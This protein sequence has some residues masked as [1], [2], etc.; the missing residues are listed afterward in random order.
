MPSFQGKVGPPITSGNS[1]LL[2]VS[3]H[4][5][6]ANT[7]RLIQHSIITYIVYVYSI[8]ACDRLIYLLTLCLPKLC[9]ECKQFT[10]Y[11]RSLQSVPC[12]TSQKLPLHPRSWR[13][14]LDHPRRPLTKRPFLAKQTT[15]D[16]NCPGFEVM[17]IYT[18]CIHI[19]IILI[20]RYYWISP[21]FLRNWIT[22]FYP[23][24][25]PN[26]FTTD[27]ISFLS[28]ILI[29]SLIEVVNPVYCWSFVS[30]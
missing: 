27:Y 5:I 6:C 9:V 13:S 24:D 16:L 14:E 25:T 11:V 18:F 3:Q 21:V 7:L 1:L 29:L 19:L 2:K 23:Q 30:N 4:N 22:I 26:L 28:T 15:F 8:I 17:L 20:L 10:V 12:H